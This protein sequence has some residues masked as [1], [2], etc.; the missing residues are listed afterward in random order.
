MNLTPATMPEQ[1]LG[2]ISEYNAA[3][4]GHTCTAWSVATAP[5]N[6]LSI[7][8]VHPVLHIR[9]IEDRFIPVGRSVLVG[10]RDDSQR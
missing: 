5:Q 1:N 9:Y 4:T 7:V 6:S 3:D 2:Y 10:W 8:P